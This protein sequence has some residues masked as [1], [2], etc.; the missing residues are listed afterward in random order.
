MV[1]TTFSLYSANN[2]PASYITAPRSLQHQ[3][4]TLS[5]F[6][7]VIIGDSASFFGAL[8]YS[9]PTP[10]NNLA[11]FL[12]Q[13][14]KLFKRH[15]DRLFRRNIAF[16]TAQFI[17]FFCKIKTL[18]SSAGNFLSLTTSFFP[19]TRIFFVSFWRDPYQ[20][21]FVF[22]YPVCVCVCVDRVYL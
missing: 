2:A 19:C 8:Y 4:G 12:V 7:A 17:N 22:F 16:I 5:P 21:Y 9:A 20:C 1:M 10:Q 15:L 14:F 11:I 3:S 18:I 6:H 13:L